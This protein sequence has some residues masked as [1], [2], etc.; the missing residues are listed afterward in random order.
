MLSRGGRPE[1]YPYDQWFDGEPH[2]LT[3]GLDVLRTIR[4]AAVRRGLVLRQRKLSLGRY[5][6]KSAPRGIEGEAV[7]VAGYVLL[8]AV[9]SGVGVLC[10][11]IGIPAA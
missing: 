6:I 2:V 9:L 10:T 1:A 5:E 8:L 4:Y 11:F 3:V 7:R